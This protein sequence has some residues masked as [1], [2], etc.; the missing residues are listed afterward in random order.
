MNPDTALAGTAP[1]QIPGQHGSARVGCPGCGESAFDE[2]VLL[3]NLPVH[4]T[5]VFATP[6]E[7]QAVARGDQ[8][9]AICMG[10]G[11]V[12]NTRFDAELLDYSGAH[13][14]S[15]HFSPHFVNYARDLATRWVDEHGL[16]GTT[17]CEIGPG[18][19]DFLGLMLEAGVDHMIAVDPVLQT[20][21]IPR[22]LSDRITVY[23]TCFQP[24][25]VRPRTA[26]VCSR[27]TFEH[28]PDIGPFLGAIVEGMREAGTGLLLSEVPE[29]SRIL[30]S[31]A[32]WDLQYEHCSYFT[33]RT[34]LGLYARSGFTSGRTR[35]TYSDQYLV[36]EARLDR[37][38]AGNGWDTLQPTA[39][40][41][42]EALHQLA[43]RFSGRVAAALERW[44]AWFEDQAAAGNEVVIW[45][46]GSKGLTFLNC[47]QPRCV[48]RVVDVN[49]GLQGCYLG[50]I[51][52]PICAPQALQQEPPR[53]VLLMNPV[54]F[55]EVREM[56]NDLSLNHTELLT[57]E[58]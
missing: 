11:L 6:D 43:R 58:V 5:A 28:I 14:A 19:G 36:A 24:A 1:D 4:G 53:N 34:L 32:F 51:G 56:L 23:N 8:A 22:E 48:R 26:F 35:L 12:F 39:E 27:H 45:G 52:L 13:E 47:L 38:P 31:G 17:G 18:S 9:L 29:L 25:H 50:G 15:Q 16:A 20:A 57:V 42:I 37:A 10:C 41:D 3:A 40:E 55:T 46:G 44:G 7:A 30:A 49:Q 2:L 21:Q 33:D 54:Y